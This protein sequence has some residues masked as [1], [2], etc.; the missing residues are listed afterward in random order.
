MV[1]SALPWTGLKKVFPAMPLRARGIF[2]LSQPRFEYVEF[3]FFATTPSNPD[4]ELPEIIFCLPRQRGVQKQSRLQKR[5]RQ[6][7]LSAGNELCYVAF[8][9]SAVRLCRLI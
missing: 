6:V 4:R 3:R 1:A 5:D 7:P 2:D 8:G 9:A